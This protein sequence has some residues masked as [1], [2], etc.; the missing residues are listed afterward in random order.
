MACGAR[1]GGD[2]VEL[3]LAA[4]EVLGQGLQ[5]G[6]TLLKVELEQF[7]N[8][9][10]AGMVHG[11]LEVQ[12]FGMGVGHHLAT[13]GTAQCGGR[14]LADPLAGDETLEYVGAGHGDGLVKQV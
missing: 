5:D 6:R 14:L 7:R 8:A 3:F 12:A 2:G 1:V 9:H 13:D 10:G 4:T 11:R